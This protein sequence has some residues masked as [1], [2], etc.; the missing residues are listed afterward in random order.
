MAKATI[1]LSTL[2]EGLEDLGMAKGKKR[3][4]LEIEYN[5]GGNYGIIENVTANTQK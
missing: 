4:H 5:S 2:F 3:I 1:T